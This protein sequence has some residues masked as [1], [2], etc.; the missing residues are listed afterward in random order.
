MVLLTVGSLDD[1]LCGLAVADLVEGPQ[2]YPVVGVGPQ[3]V[4]GEGRGARVV[5]FLLQLVP[6]PLPWARLVGN[7][8]VFQNTISI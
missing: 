6:Q 2:F 1:D 5:Q 4:E 7:L 3:V 8:Q